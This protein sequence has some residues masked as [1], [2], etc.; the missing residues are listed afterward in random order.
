MTTICSSDTHNIIPVN[1]DKNNMI[2]SNTQ[3]AEFI[4]DFK[5]CNSFNISNEY[6]EWMK[7]GIPA[8]PKGCIKIV[9]QTDNN[10]A[11]LLKFTTIGDLRGVNNK[12]NIFYFPESLNLY[13][14]NSPDGGELI[15]E[16]QQKPFRAGENKKE[17]LERLLIFIPVNIVTTDTSSSKWFEKI[18]PIQAI[19]N[20]PITRNTNSL[21][22]NDV[23]PKDVFWIYNDISIHG[24]DCNASDDSANTKLYSKMHAIFFSDGAI[25]IKEQDYEIFR[26]INAANNE[27][28]EIGET[29]KTLEGGTQSNWCQA[30]YPSDSAAQAGTINSE[31]VETG[32]ENPPNV[33]DIIRTATSINKGAIFLNN[34]GTKRG[35]GEHNDIGDPFSLTCEP[36]IDADD[37][38]PLDGNRTEWVKGVYNA[39]PKGMK[40]TFWLLIFIVILTGILVSIHVFI[41]KNIG[42]F[43][44]QNEIAGRATNS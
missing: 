38:K 17:D 10:E 11:E 22:L 3:L 36:I 6:P 42:L 7:N 25:S 13:D 37:E 40:N 18:R 44:T 30:W 39:V 12:I 33:Q 14:N 32:G 31:S 23:I 16:L 8:G 21:T 15:I 20:T 28:N 35:P 19:S 34:V 24:L 41:F 1:L 4:Y 27:F 43:I 29:C 5:A 2:N 26:D 9:Q